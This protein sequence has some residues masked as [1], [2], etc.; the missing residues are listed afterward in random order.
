[1][2]SESI[3][4]AKMGL[5]SLLLQ[6]LDSTHV[7]KLQPTIE[8][9]I[10]LG[11]ASPV[12]SDPFSVLINFLSHTDYPAKYTAIKK[13]REMPVKQQFEHKCYPTG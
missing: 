13:R 10:I 6:L 3:K 8:W 7:R 1:M 5:Q 9:Q 4:S 12:L 2:Q 11:R